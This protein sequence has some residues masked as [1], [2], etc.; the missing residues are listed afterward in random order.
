MRAR[1]SPAGPGDSRLAHAGGASACGVDFPQADR[2]LP[3]ATP[4]DSVGGGRNTSRPAFSYGS[5]VPL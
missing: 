4:V 3:I 5:D 1:Y 2:I